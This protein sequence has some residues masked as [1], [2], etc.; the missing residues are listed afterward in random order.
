MSRQLS[1]KKR[2]EIQSLKQ[3]GY[4]MRRIVTLVGCSK[5]TVAL[6]CK[7]NFGSVKDKKR[8]RRKKK[9]SEKTKR[10]INYLYR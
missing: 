8:T 6:W 10:T 4:S 9:L 2:L 5:N 7:N 3:H 1:S